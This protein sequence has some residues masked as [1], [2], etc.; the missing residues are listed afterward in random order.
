MQGC[1][2]PPSGTALAEVDGMQ[3]DTTVDDGEQGICVAYGCTNRNT[4]VKSGS[5]TPRSKEA[6]KQRE[7]M[8][9]A[10]N[11]DAKRDRARAEE[12]LVGLDLDGGLSY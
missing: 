3:Q 9:T 7:Q 2:S 1:S 11:I 8:K 12:T 5:L 6:S 10:E 4:T